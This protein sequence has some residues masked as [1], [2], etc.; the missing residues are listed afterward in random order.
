MAESN[1]YGRN[2]LLLDCILEGLKYFWWH[3]SEL[4]TSKDIM[5][6]MPYK[7]WCACQG[8]RGSTDIKIIKHYLY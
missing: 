6:D 3:F 8:G 2:T 5:N 1:F 4:S 7:F